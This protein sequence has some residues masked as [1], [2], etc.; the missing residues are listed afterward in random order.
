MSLPSMQHPEHRNT[1]RVQDEENQKDDHERQSHPQEVV[2]GVERD[3]RVGIT[4]IVE[5][6]DHLRPDIEET[7]R[8]QTD[9]HDHMA[10]VDDMVSDAVVAVPQR[11]A[12]SDQHETTALM[13]RQSCPRRW[14]LTHGSGKEPQS[15]AER[16]GEWSFHDLDEQVECF[17]VPLKAEGRVVRIAHFDRVERFH[18]FEGVT[19]DLNAVA[20][21]R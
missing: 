17:I 1:P 6:M 20:L 21:C 11:V 4:V 10:A 12:E 7:E 5:E 15:S 9:A 2:H 3:V 13:V 19:F 18:R 14:L 8:G 16:R